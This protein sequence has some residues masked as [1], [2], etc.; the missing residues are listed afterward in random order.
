MP[1][2]SQPAEVKHWSFAGLLLTPAC[3]AACASCYLACKPAAATYM[4]AQRALELWRGL[5]AASPHGC[6]V[7]L[8]G[9]EPFVDWPALIDICRRAAAESLHPHK[10]ETNA[11]W[12]TD[13]ALCVSRLQ[14]LDACGLGKLAIS[15]DPYHQQFVPIERP[16][17]LAQ[18]AA[19]VLGQERVQVRWRDWLADGFDTHAMDAA[20]RRKLFAQWASDGR[21]RLNGRAATELAP[22]LEGKPASEFAGKTCHEALLRSRHVHVDAH[23]YVMP[24]TCAGVSL[25]CA[26][27]QAVGDVWHSV[28]NGW[29]QRPVLATLA[30][31]GPAGLAQLLHEHG[32]Q[33][34]P[35]DAGFASA[36]HL[37]HEVRVRLRRAG[38]FCDELA[39]GELYC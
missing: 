8:A 1:H 4:P 28:A 23:G 22:L 20:S 29:R 13:K 26:S 24:G 7:H 21:D 36:C 16:R 25:G 37:C 32:A 6:R 31:R 15:A 9:G 3:T 17:L 38:A 14:E 30:T 34:L 12:A 39:P 19:Q 2:N 33:E 35:P 10:L 27:G 11:S 18:T 5:A